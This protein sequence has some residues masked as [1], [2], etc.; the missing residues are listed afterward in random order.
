MILLAFDTAQGALSAA[1]FEADG[2][3]EPV[4]LSHFFEVR[5]RGHA[6]RLLPVL[7][8]V[9]AEAGTGFADLDALAVTVGPGT[10]TGLRVGLS[11]ARGIALAR[12]L[13][14]VGVTTLEAVAAPVELHGNERLAVSF[15]AR[16]EEVYFQIFEQNQGA[17]TEPAL[18]PLEIAAENAAQHKAAAKLFLAGTGAPLLAERLLPLGVE[19]LPAETRP[20]PDAR[21][22][23]KIAIRRIRAQGLD[24]FRV[25]PAP[26]YIRA[27]DAKLPGGL[28]LE[29][30]QAQ[31][32]IRG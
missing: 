21:A 13:P 23:G 1:L 26:L 16:R 12:K 3:G 27:P 19:T 25:P 15:D 4:L 18:F 28:T 22:V 10:F 9:L 24:A 7:E 6:E 11:A 30:A 14:C 20:E 5:S 32:R 17:V 31:G 2:E 8:E 29:E